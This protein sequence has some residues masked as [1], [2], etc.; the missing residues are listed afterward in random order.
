MTRK[1]WIQLF[2][3]TAGALL[4]ALLPPPQGI[5]RRGMVF[6]GIFLATLALIILDTVP[7]WA[8][9]VFAM[10]ACPLT[11]VC[12]LPQA[13]SGFTTDTILLI[14]AGYLFAVALSKTT[15]MKRV[16]LKLVSV[17]P[18]TERYGGRVLAVMCTSLILCPL[19]PDLMSKIGIMGPIT[20]MIDQ[21]VGDEKNSRPAL[22]LFFA[23]YI[24]CYILSN[25]FLSGHTNA[26]MLMGYMTDPLS[27]PVKS[28]G[29]WLSMTWPWVL[30]LLAGS[31]FYAAVLCRPKGETAPFP[32]ALFREKYAALGKVR[33]REALTLLTVAVFVPSLLAASRLGLSIP[34]LFY[35]ADLVLALGG[36]IRF[37]DLKK[38]VPWHLIV[39]ISML[40]AIPANISRLGW[41][42]LIA[43][44]LTPVLGPLVTNVWLLLPLVMGLTFVL[45]F[46]IPSQLTTLTIVL[47]VFSSFLP[48]AGISLAV[49]VWA[50]Y[51]TGNTWYLPASN[52]LAMAAFSMNGGCVEEKAFC[53]SSWLYLALTVVSMMLSIPLWKSLG[54]C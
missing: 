23:A 13:L 9:A 50:A 30:V 35:G 27:A 48:Q 43:R 41:A 28:W 38:A 1:K 10:A 47:S 25:A 54:L 24:P 4:V 31:F 37:S 29:G 7:D 17:F 21:V 49:V 42:D 26:L 15:A 6:A 5:D 22:G 44:L 3:I 16:G 32:K 11:G 39:F 18:G 53:K 20:A 8:A 51:M 33:G 40:L 19:Y 2:L 12:T 45:R 52:A 46:F 36:L 34:L 14:L